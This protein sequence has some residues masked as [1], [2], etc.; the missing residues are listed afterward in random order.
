MVSFIGGKQLYDSQAAYLGNVVVMIN[1]KQVHAID[2]AEV[3][4]L[5]R[6]AAIPLR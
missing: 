4:L 5:S 1:G 2:V 6:F 3:L